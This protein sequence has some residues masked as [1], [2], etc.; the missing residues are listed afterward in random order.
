MSR[1]GEGGRLGA[2]AGGALGG[3]DALYGGEEFCAGR[4]L[5]A[6]D[7]DGERG[8]VGDDV[9]YMSGLERADGQDG[10]VGG[11]DLSADDGLEADDYVGS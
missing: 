5:D 3:D 9:F 4:G 10:D 6:A 11:V 1:H 7:V 8:G 2:A